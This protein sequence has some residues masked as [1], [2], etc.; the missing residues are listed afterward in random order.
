MTHENETP[1]T[2]P[3]ERVGTQQDI[4]EWRG[5]TIRTA[6]QASDDTELQALGH[7]LTDQQIAFLH[8]AFNEV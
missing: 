4:A 6:L 2:W 5:S 3:V 7:N 8:T 1:E